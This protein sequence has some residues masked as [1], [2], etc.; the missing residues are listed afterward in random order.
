MR[1]RGAG[2]ESDVGKTRVVGHVMIS[3]GGSGLVADSMEI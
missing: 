1:G 3:Q 2:C